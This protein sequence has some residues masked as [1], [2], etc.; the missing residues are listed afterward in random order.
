MPATGAYNEIRG[1]N[2]PGAAGAESTMIDY[3][4]AI[5]G[6]FR[7][8]AGANDMRRRGQMDESL[9]G[10]N[11]TADEWLRVL[12]GLRESEKPYSIG[13]YNSLFN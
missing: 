13:A 10:Y 11:A 12:K 7:D 6:L 1:V 8:E 5:S 4:K 2:V 9:K 3:A